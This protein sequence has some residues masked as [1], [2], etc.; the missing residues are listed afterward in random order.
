MRNLVRRDAHTS[1]LCFFLAQKL[2]IFQPT[3][4]GCWI[5]DDSYFGASFVS[6]N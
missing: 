2:V 4:E 3:V 5:I 6:Y 1:I